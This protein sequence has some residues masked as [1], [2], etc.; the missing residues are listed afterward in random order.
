MLHHRGKRWGFEFKYSYGP[1][2]TKSMHVAL[3]DLRLER[4]FA[5]Y[6]GKDAYPL[7]E[8]VEALPLVQVDKRLEKLGFL[9]VRPKA[10]SKATARRK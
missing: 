4:I 5:I 8:R 1:V 6:P 3:Q 10:T 7:H 9:P 2:M